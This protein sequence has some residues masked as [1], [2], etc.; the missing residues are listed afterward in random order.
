MYTQTIAV[1]RV[2]KHSRTMAVIRLHV[3]TLTGVVE[4][5]LMYFVSQQGYSSC[6]RSD[7]K[8][9][10]RIVRGPERVLRVSPLS[11]NSYKGVAG[12]H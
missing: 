6:S 1:V 4:S 5:V 3:N 9:L 12:G 7:K 10:Q 2:E 11:K 8:A